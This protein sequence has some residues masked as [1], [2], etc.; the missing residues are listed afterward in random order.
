MTLI[1]NF[2]VIST[3]KSIFLC[4]W[5]SICGDLFRDSKD[6]LNIKK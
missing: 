6:I 1:P 5:E 4:D 2:H 3:E